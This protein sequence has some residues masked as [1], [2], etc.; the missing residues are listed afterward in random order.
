M[1]ASPS[2]FQSIIFDSGAVEHPG[3]PADREWLAGMMSDIYDCCRNKRDAQPSRR[4]AGA[5]NRYSAT[6]RFVLPAG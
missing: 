2:V 5:D 1:I 4:V 3:E 6:R